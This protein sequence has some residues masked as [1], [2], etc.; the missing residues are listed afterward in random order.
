MMYM[1]GKAYLLEALGILIIPW[2]CLKN[3]MMGKNSQ[4]CL[5]TELVFGCKFI[6]YLWRIWKTS[7]LEFGK[8]IGRCGWNW[9][10]AFG[11]CLGKYLRI[12]VKINV[13]EPL[14]RALHFV[15][16]DEDQPI[17]LWL[18][19]G[20]LLEYCYF[21]GHIEH[22]QSECLIYTN[23]PTSVH[24]HELNF[25]QHMRATSPNHPNRKPSPPHRDNPKTQKT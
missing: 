14:E 24:D 13:T 9:Y 23:Q 21:C 1:K 7:G 18:S 20:R 19:Y 25:W 3:L 5:L 8:T 15:W 6:I 16:E 4:R 17:K 10:R 12:R 2:L 22:S 11:D